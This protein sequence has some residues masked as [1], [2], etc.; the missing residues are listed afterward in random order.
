[1]KLIDPNTIYTTTFP[2][3]KLQIKEMLAINAERS[4][5]ST[6][7]SLIF[8]RYELFPAYPSQSPAIFE[9][10][11]RAIPSYTQLYLAIPSYTQLY[12]ALPSCQIEVNRFKH[13][14]DNYTLQQTIQKL[15]LRVEKFWS[16][17][18]NIPGTHL[19]TVRDI[20]SLQRPSLAILEFYR[21]DIHSSTQLSKAT[22]LKLI[23]SHTIQ[24][25][26]S[27]HQRLKL[28]PKYI[29]SIHFLH[30][31]TNFQLPQDYPRPGYPFTP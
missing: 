25:K 21:R 6:S 14:L 28:L 1:M 3:Q 19:Y 17:P 22:R 4:C 15:Q 24:I 27:A 2:N 7:R 10:T 30:G 8:T 13:N 16:L 29:T 12:L 23:G 31:T 9:F 26:K 18:Q 11:R 5:P 20:S